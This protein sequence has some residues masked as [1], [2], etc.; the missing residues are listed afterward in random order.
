MTE[1]AMT[2]LPKTIE[3]RIACNTLQHIISRGGDAAEAAKRILA[4]HD[5][6][7]EFMARRRRAQHR[8]GN[9]DSARRSA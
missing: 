7:L 5:L 3:Y 4:D 8:P 1:I 9:S 6:F 2:G